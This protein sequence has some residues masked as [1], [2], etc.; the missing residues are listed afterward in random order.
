MCSQMSVWHHRQLI[1][2][3]ESN[4]PVLSRVIRIKAVRTTMFI[5]VLIPRSCF[6]CTKPIAKIPKLC[7]Q[8]D[9]FAYRIGRGRGIC[10]WTQHMIDHHKHVSLLIVSEGYEC[11]VPQT[12]LIVLVEGLAPAIVG[13]VLSLPSSSIHDSP[14]QI[15]MA[16]HVSRGKRARRVFYIG[17]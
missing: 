12:F 2:F 1:S 3:S 5:Y 4:N 17:S 8:R 7:G 6:K 16:S 15:C 9:G 10:Q 14:M 13:A 11:F